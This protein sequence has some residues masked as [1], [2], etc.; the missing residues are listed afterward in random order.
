MGRK[1]GEKE[2]RIHTKMN[3]KEKEE[4]INSKMRRASLRISK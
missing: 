2:E 1:G 3:G 4:R